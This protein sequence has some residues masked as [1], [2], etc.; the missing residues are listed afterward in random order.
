MVEGQAVERSVLEEVVKLMAMLGKAVWLAVVSTTKMAFVA[1]MQFAT[2]PARSPG[3][4]IV[5]DEVLIIEAA[6]EAVQKQV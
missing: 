3:T 5:I 2:V 6:P 1:A 4:K